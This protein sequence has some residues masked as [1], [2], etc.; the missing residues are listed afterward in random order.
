MQQHRAAYA[1]R[2][3]TNA[4]KP[5]RE[6]SQRSSKCHRGYRASQHRQSATKLISKRQDAHLRAYLQAKLCCLNRG[7]ITTRTS[8]HDNHV[9][10]Y[11]RTLGAGN[12]SV[13][14]QNTGGSSGGHRARSAGLETNR[15]QYIMNQGKMKKYRSGASQSNDS[16][17]SPK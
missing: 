9:H 1:R 7:N 15:H 2:C 11:E 14:K 10:I 5:L 3:A 12:R 6:C 8:T 4:T 13:L 17:H 16:Q